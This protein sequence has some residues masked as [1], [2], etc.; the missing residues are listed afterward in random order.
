MANLN[1][2]TKPQ[3][4]DGLKLSAPAFPVGF[5]VPIVLFC[6][7]IALAIAAAFFGEVESPAFWQ[8]SGILS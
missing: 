4:F 5:G 2:S 8:E 7:A 1:I 6:L 3:Q